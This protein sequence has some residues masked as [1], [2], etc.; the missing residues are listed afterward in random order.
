[1]KDGLYEKILDSISK[2]ELE[3]KNYKKIRNIDESELARVISISY[4]KIIRETLSQITN[5][6]EKLEFIQKLNNTIGI[7]DFEYEN[8]RFKELLA[9]HNDESGYSILN[10]YRPR[11]SISTSTLFTG[12]SRVTLESELS[13]EIRTA[14]EVDFLVSFIKFSGLRLIYEDLV[15]FTKENK[16]RVITTSYMGASDYKAILDLAK[17]PNTEVKISYDIKR[18]RLHAKAYYFKRSTGFSTAYIGSSNL[19][20]PA[21]SNGLEWNLKVSEYT[22]KDVIDSFIKNFE[23]YWNDDEFVT[24]SPSNEKET[25]DLKEA[26]RLPEKTDTPNVYFDLKPYSHQKEILEDLKLER[27][28]Y[29]SYKNLLVAA[30]GTG[31]TMVAAFDY[32]EQRKHGDKK[33]LFLA[34]RKEI[35]EQGLSTFRNVLKDHNF[36]ELWV[37]GNT[38]QEDTHLF[39]SIQTLNSSEKYKEFPRDYFDY[40]VI[41]ESHHTT[42]SSYLRIIK[43]YEPKILLGLTATPE[44]MDG[45]N[46]LEY[47]NNRIASEI[48]LTDAINRKL[49]SPFHYFG[50]TDPVDLEHLK[51]TRGGYE[52]SELENVYT[53]SKQRVQVILDA[54]DRYLKDMHTFKA[55]GFC[56]SIKHA[57]FM[58]ES[59]NYVGIP[60]MALHSGTK[61]EDRDLAKMKL[62]AGE[63]NCI[64]TVDLFN[65]GVDIPE[66]DT[67]LFLRPTESLTIFIQQLGRGLRLSE[68]KEVLTVLDF[69]GQAHVNY[70]FSIKLRALTGKTKRSIK[71]EINDDFPNMPIGCHIKLEKVAKEYILSNIQSSIFNVRDLRRMI[72]NFKNNFTNKLNL[73]NFLDNYGIDKDRFYSKYSFYKLLAETGYKEDYKVKHRS[74]LKQALRRFSRIDS[75]R[76]LCFAQR[77]LIGD[78]DVSLFTKKE[79]LMLGMIHYTIWGDKPE[80][81]YEKSLEDLKKYNLDIVREILDIIEYNKSKLKTIE[82]VY[83]N[84]EIPLDIY[85]SYSLDQIM[86]AFEKTTE[87]HK[88]PIREGVLYIEDKRTDLFFIT[89]NKNEED[90]LPS[91]MYN[92]YAKNSELFNWESQSTTSVESAT[93]QRYINDT[94]KEHKVLIFVRQTKKDYGVAS[95][96]IF[97]GNARYVSHKGSNPIQIVWKMDHTIP[98]KIIRESSL[99]VVN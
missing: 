44:R 34:H 20:N 28:E 46:I 39:A 71:E 87:N 82:I 6:S 2:Q 61:S 55:L 47:F 32:K 85:A 74:E 81:S 96:Y 92:D 60:S 41:D 48:R 25:K 53:K 91:T 51:W 65:E 19:S 63:I 73:K 79:K 84:E 12:N 77:I 97:L 98:E 94:S 13:R 24:F 30:T 86:A 11:T 52:I 38:P 58:A 80:I 67:V 4:Q 45:E 75:K 3:N 43:Y 83:E 99:R 27:E 26:L 90:Y 93:G 21:L 54:M 8:E 49:L 7:E 95:P 33:L 68:D 37:A 78:V 22:S 5:A 56:V 36:G 18:T 57:E 31:K 35:L 1:M 29:N 88:Y 17:L 40:V 66:I 72:E 59:F 10:K 16:L 64:F 69:V 76:L 62:N 42:A 89:I 9:V 23:T 14:N 70:D 15:E 50:V